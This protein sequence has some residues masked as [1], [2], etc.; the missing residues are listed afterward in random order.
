MTLSKEQ[1]ATLVRLARSVVDNFVRGAE[2]PDSEEWDS[3]FLAENRGAFVTLKESNGDLRGCI[4]YPYP[5]KK[6]GDAVVESAIGAAARDPRFPPVRAE[7]L[8]QLLVEVSA[9]TVPEVIE[10]ASRSKLPDSIRI[11]VDGLIVSGMGSSGLLLP[12][13]ATEYH[14]SP[15]DFLSETCVKAGLMPDAWLT[16]RVLVK[17]FQAEVFSEST[18]R[19][20]VVAEGDAR[21]QS[22]D[23]RSASSF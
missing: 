17:R 13:V 7:E 14:L 5:V 16:D 6:L 12:Q 19:G 10:S 20:P 21:G 11:G 3:P 8:D 4:G 23:Q 18:P 15:T 22:R 1:G 2:V 9:L